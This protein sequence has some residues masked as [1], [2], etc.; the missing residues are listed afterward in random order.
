MFP[1]SGLESGQ[2]VFT[3]GKGKTMSEMNF[4]TPLYAGLFGIMLVYL[5][6]RIVRLRNKYQI[7]MGDGGHN[8]LIAATRAQ[9]NL[10]E[11]L[12]VSLILMLMLEFLAT[13]IWILHGLGIWLLIARVLHLKGIKDPSGTSIHRK[14]GTRLTWAQ[15]ISASLLCIVGSLGWVF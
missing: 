8:A 4:I 6:W 1:L 11:Y 13:S 2:D 14:I 15:L 9:G 5:S 12:P 7:K 10:V 3:S